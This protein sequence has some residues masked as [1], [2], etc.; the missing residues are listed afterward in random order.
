MATGR[1]AASRASAP[2]PAAARDSILARDRTEGVETLARV[3]SRDGYQGCFIYG[4]HGTFDH[5]CGYA[6]PNGWARFIDQD[7]FEN[8]VHTTAWGHCDEDVLHRAIEEMR[9]MHAAYQPFFLTC[10]T[11]SNHLTVHILTGRIQEDPEAK[12]RKHAVKYSD[13][14]L[15]DFFRR[16]KAEPFWRD[17]IFAVVADHGARVYGSEEIP[18]KSYQIPLVIAGPA[19]APQPRRIDTLGCQLDVA[20]TLLGLIGRPYRTLFFGRDLLRAGDPSLCLMHHNRSIAAYGSG[21]MAVFGLNKTITYYRGDPKRGD[22]VPMAEPDAAARELAADGEA[23]FRVADELYM[24]RQ[25]LLPEP[26]D[27][28]SLAAHSR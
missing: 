11:V 15:G 16:A 25:Y 5:L 27:N 28:Q 14:A 9:S 7:D 10:M 21:R 3:L 12:S 13:W 8:P 22:L 17:T 20:P 18:I 6:E 23:L 24:G 1:S 4:G 19:A 2:A 26:T